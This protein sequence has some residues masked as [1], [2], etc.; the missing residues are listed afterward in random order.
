[1]FILESA[2]QVENFIAEN[3]QHDAFKEYICFNC[4]LSIC[5]RKIVRCEY[6][7]VTMKINKSFYF[8]IY[9]LYLL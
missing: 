4:Y 8:F 1:M 5:R 7:T 3:G 6:V 2:A 9:K